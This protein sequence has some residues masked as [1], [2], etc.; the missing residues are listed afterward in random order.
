F[1]DPK[2]R[3]MLASP[4][5]FSGLFPTCRHAM[6]AEA[7][8]PRLSIIVPCYNEEGNLPELVRRTREVLDLYRLTAEILLVD[9]KSRDG[10]RK[11]IED[12]ARQHPDVRGLYHD[13]N[14]GIVGG[15]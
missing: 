11:V 7:T 8:P 3:G 10:T 2:E 4:L 12:L 6:S 13:E 14:R 5:V 9:D 1:V 15:W